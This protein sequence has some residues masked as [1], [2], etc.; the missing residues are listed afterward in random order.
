MGTIKF[1]ETS[2]EITSIY[3]MRPNQVE[4]GIM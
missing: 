4:V 3:E 1:Q 2:N